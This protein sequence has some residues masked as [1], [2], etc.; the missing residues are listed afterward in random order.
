MYLEKISSPF[1]RMIAGA[2][3]GGLI[4]LIAGLLFALAITVI[5]SQFS[6]HRGIGELY[7]VATFI[8]MGLGV[9]TGV[10]LGAR[11]VNMKHP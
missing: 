7:Q 9:L 1:I 10:V 6:N 2:L 8:G 4:G 5:S 3:L 11:Y